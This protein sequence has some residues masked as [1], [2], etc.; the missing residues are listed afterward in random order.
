MSSSHTNEIERL[1]REEPDPRN[2]AFLLILAR[3]DD[4]L[5]ENTRQT[6]DIGTKLDA[7]LTRYDEQARADA[8]LRSQA[9]GAWKVLAYVVTFAQAVL[10]AGGAWLYGEIRSL[11][12]LDA[13]VIQRIGLVESTVKHMEK[14]YAP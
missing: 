10:I 13:D 7:H 14:A 5:R 4:S 1:I 3:I 9:Q 11:H 2:R 6:Q 12:A 8:S